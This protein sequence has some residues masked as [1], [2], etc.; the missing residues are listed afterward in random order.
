MIA[1]YPVAPLTAPLESKRTR[2]VRAPR[3]GIL[4]LEIQLG[5][6]VEQGDRLGIITDPA[7]RDGKVVRASMAGIVLGHTVSPVVH[8]GDG[9]VHIAGDL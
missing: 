2:W 5:Q 3:G 9:L 6:R 4:R 1:E 8:P 7:V